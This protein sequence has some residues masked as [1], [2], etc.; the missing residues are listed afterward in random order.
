MSSTQ[1]ETLKSI[2]S[3]EQGSSAHDMQIPQTP[4]SNPTSEGI[5]QFSGQPISEAP[6]QLPDSSTVTCL[7]FSMLA[8]QSSLLE[9]LLLVA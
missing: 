3:Q 1:Q 9:K 6:T 5:G 2:V 4:G 7:L 8:L